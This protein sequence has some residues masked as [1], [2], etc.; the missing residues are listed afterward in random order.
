M[1]LT[2]PECA[3]RYSVADDSVGAEGRTVRCTQCGLTWRTDRELALEL[4]E[5]A[6]VATE[7]PISAPTAADELPRAFRERIA[8]QRN[9]RRA[10]GAGLLLG[11][12]AALLALLLMG[13]VAGRDSVVQVWPKSASAF[14]AIGLPV[15]SVGLVI[16]E[17]SAQVG[18][19]DGRPTVLVTGRLRNIRGRPVASPPLRFTLLDAQEQDLG[20]RI[21]RVVNADVPARGS[22]TFT[23]KLHNPPDSV[24]DVEIGFHLADEGAQAGQAPAQAKAPAH[25]AELRPSHAEPGH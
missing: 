15:N 20:T 6:S 10:A 12:G 11:G 14:A 23:A 13:I 4:H 24:Q 5:A 3:T 16:E 21:S 25:A 19:E 17:Q 1:I 9:G 22:R 2:C 7:A 18:W 8:A